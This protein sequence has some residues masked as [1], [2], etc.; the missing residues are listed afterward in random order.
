MGGEISRLLEEKLR[1]EFALKGSKLTMSEVKNHPQPGVKEVKMEVK[2]V[3]HRLG[4]SHYRVLAE[5][6]RILIVR[7]KERP[8]LRTEMKGSPPSPSQSLPYFFP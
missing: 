2:R 7:V 1:T 6:S 5:H 4:L 3:L 8:R